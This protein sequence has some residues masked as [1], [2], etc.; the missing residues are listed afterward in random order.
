M[1]FFSSFDADEAFPLAY[2]S[3]K[4]IKILNRLHPVK[5]LCAACLTYLKKKFIPELLFRSFT[6]F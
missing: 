6:L 3:V 5:M 1:P 2:N 4:I